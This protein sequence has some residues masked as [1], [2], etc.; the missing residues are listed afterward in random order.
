MAKE[1][2]KEEKILKQSNFFI[3]IKNNMPEVYDC[4]Y[5]YLKQTEYKTEISFNNVRIQQ[6]LEFLPN[7]KDCAILETQLA[8]QMT[9]DLIAL[10]YKDIEV[11]DMYQD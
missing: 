1:K 6:Y 4:V 2:S 9:K 11:V 3:R 7:K 10:G 5:L 8:I